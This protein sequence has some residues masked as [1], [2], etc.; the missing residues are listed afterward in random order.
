V[1]F[2]LPFMVVTGAV[3]KDNPLPVTLG[4]RQISF[5][6]TKSAKSTHTAA[7]LRSKDCITPAS[8]PCYDAR[9]VV[10][11]VHLVRGVEKPSLPK[12]NEGIHV[13][14]NRQEVLE[15]TKSW[16][17]K[18][19]LTQLLKDINRL[20]IDLQ[21]LEPKPYAFCASERNCPFFF[22]V[23]SILGMLMA[24]LSFMLQWRAWITRW[25]I[26][27]GIML[28]LTLSCFMCFYSQVHWEVPHETIHSFAV[29][30]SKRYG[31]QL[32]YGFQPVGASF[33]V[34]TP[35]EGESDEEE[36]V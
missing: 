32:V 3:H 33:F 26:A 15:N 14:G 17:D 10:I 25:M 11:A 9:R 21:L 36:E 8:S 7:T 24:L 2:T 31:L 35:K 23:V 16:L 30:W 34:L 4:S 19:I 27:S 5:K 22:A 12:D 20:A 18:K 6:S 13:V 1:N 29:D 28:V